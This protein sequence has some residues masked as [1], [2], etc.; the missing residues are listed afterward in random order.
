VWQGRRPIVVEVDVGVDEGNE[1]RGDSASPAL[2][3]TRP[4]IGRESDPRCPGFATNGGV[5][6]SST[7]DP[8]RGPGLRLGVERRN[9]DRDVG[10]RERRRGWRRMDGAGLT[11]RSVS[12]PWPA[13]SGRPCSI[14][15]TTR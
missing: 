15:S 8:P 7:A 4:A 9:D 5:L 14:A 13:G 11:G 2:R 10:S 3:R 12:L 1:R 6:A